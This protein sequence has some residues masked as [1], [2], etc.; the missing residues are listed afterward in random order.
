MLNLID[1]PL[2]KARER[3]SSVVMLPVQKRVEDTLHGLSRLRPVRALARPPA[4]SGLTPVEGD[5]GLPFV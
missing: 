4:G 2:T 1:A 5:A 3:M